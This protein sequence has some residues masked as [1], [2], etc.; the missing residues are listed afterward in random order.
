[1]AGIF[2]IELH[3]GDN[4]VQDD[5]SDD[6]VIDTANADYDT[7]PNVNDVLVTEDCEQVQLCE[8]NVNPGKEKV[9]PKDF[10][11]CKILGEGGYGKVFQVIYYFYQK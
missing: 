11:L 7:S 9:G 6:D 3:D 1:M 5:D 10:E 4:A 2:D 8:Q